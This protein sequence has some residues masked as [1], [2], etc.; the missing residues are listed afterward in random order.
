MSIPALS[1]Q[2]TSGA[3]R[4][5]RTSERLRTRSR[6]RSG[7][8]RRRRRARPPGR[9]RS[10]S[11]PGSVAIERAMASSWSRPGRSWS[12]T[13]NCFSSST[14]TC[15][16]GARMTTKVRACLPALIW[17]SRAWTTSGLP[18]KRWKLTQHQQRRAVGRGQGVQRPDGGQRVGGVGEAAGLGRLAGQ[19]QAPVDVPGGQG[20]AVGA[21]EAGDLGQGVLVL[22]GLDPEAGEAGADVLREALGERHGGLL[23]G[24]GFGVS[25]SG[26]DGI[27]RAGSGGLI[28]MLAGLLA[29][30]ELG[31]ERL[32]G[33]PAEGL[34]D[35]P[36]GLAA[37]GAG[38]APG[39]DLV[40]PFGQTVISMVLLKTHL[41]PVIVSLIEPSARGCST[42]EWPRLRASIPAFSTAY[43][44]MKRSSCSCGPQRLIVV[45]EATA[46][47]WPCRRRRGRA[48]RAA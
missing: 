47:R 6:P 33:P 1:S 12:T 28:E 46:R 22:E 19:A 32:G 5:W 48:S 35:E 45:V 18:R 38:E 25:G 9:R 44:C 30:V 40:S 34:L 31:G 37:L 7:S 24:D 17:L 42:T 4:P 8:A 10:G 29:L 36:A 43:A 15:T 23:G 13:T 11:S 41:R 27:A 20:P 26:R 3:S 14:G 39:L 21:A 2:R 16:T